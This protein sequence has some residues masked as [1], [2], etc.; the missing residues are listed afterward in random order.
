MP[1]V[2]Y[3]Q[4]LKLRLFHS[5]FGPSAGILKTRRRFRS[6]TVSLTTSTS[7]FLTHVCYTRLVL[8]P[9]ST[10][11]SPSDNCKTIKWLSSVIRLTLCR[12]KH[13]LILVVAGVLSLSSQAPSIMP[14]SLVLLLG[15]TRQSG[16]QSPSESN[17]F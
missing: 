4:V 5:P 6:G 11:T 14:V 1:E 2:I 13:F 10:E 17:N 9:M 7:G 3:A 12:T 16:A 15:T 8:S